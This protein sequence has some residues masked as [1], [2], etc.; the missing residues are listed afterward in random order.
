[1][2]AIRA[3]KYLE[4]SKCSVLLPESGVAMQP[5]RFCTQPPAIIGVLA[6]N[7][8]KHRQLNQIRDPCDRAPAR[9]LQRIRLIA[10]FGFQQKRQP[11]FS[12]S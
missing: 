2:T 9:E 4:A 7:G 11:R 1:V 8:L 5:R 6:R 12:I 10:V 3:D